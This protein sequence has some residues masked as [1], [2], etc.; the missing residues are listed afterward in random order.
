MNPNAVKQVDIDKLTVRVERLVEQ[1][2]KRSPRLKTIRDLWV[3]FSSRPE[4]GSYGLLVA[5]VSEA[6]ETSSH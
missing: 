3:L 6:E 2:G 5:A 4:Q 1:Y